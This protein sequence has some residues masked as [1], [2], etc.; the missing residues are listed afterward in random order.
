MVS[1]ITG[2]WIICSP[3]C[4]G[5]KQCKDPNSPTPTPDC[6][7][8]VHHQGPLLLTWNN[9]NPSMDRNH[10]HYKVWEEITYPFPNFNGVAV[11]AWE[12][13]SNFISTLYN[14]CIYFFLLGWK[15]IHFIKRASRGKTLFKILWWTWSCNEWGHIPVE[16][17]LT[18]NVTVYTSI[19]EIFEHSGFVFNV[20]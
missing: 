16:G 18:Q 7:P 15:L 9:F 17:L 12:W 19:Y 10:V 13:I 20:S 14:G 6:V 1:Q 5:L 8:C 11:E 4:K 3:A 2:K